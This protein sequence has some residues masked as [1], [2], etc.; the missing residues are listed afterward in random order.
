MN[1]LFLMVIVLGFIF[2]GCLTTTQPLP[3]VDDTNASTNLI[4]HWRLEEGEFASDV[5]EDHH[6]FNIF[7]MP[8]TQTLM[9]VGAS[10][11]V[12]NEV[13]A[14]KV[15]KD[16]GAMCYDSTIAQVKLKNWKL[17][18]LTDHFSTDKDKVFIIVAF[19]VNTNGELE[20]YNVKD[21]SVSKAVTDGKLSKVEDASD[22]NSAPDKV[23][24]WLAEL[25]EDDLKLYAK[26]QRIQ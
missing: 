17:I 10:D 22:I 2:S 20:V 6:F 4:G 24:A 1:K 15:C 13:D 9:M 21:E 14:F 23:I 19:E 25:K 3:G 8:D 7:L 5:S 16:D 12:I 11:K 26:Y 18:S